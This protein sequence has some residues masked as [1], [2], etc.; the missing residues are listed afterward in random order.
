MT[1]VVAE[2]VERARA[3][4]RSGDEDA[5]CGAV[6]RPGGDEAVRTKPWRAR[7]TL[8]GRGRLHPSGR[9]VEK[10]R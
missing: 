8:V 6:G 9:R 7:E 3:E 4:R 5:R 1:N 2:P 10:R